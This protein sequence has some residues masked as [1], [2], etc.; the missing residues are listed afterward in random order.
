M[1]AA[2]VRFDYTPTARQAAAHGSFADELLY[3]GAAGGGKTDYL[4]AEVLTTL[5]TFPGSNGVI[6]RRTY[7]DLRRPGGIVE[8][9]LMRVPPELGT[10][11]AGEHKWR[12]R[13][14][15]L[16]E[17]GHLQRDATVLQY[18]GAEFA[19]V[20]FD[21]LEQ[22]TEYQYLYLRSRLRVAGETAAEFRR[23]GWRPRSIASANPGG[24]GHGWVKARF[25]DA[26]V[27]P[28]VI[29]RP[30]ATLDE[31]CPGTRVFLPARVDDNPHLDDSYVDRLRNLPEDDRRAL[32]EGDWDVYAGQR[33]RSFRRA[34]HVV[35]PEDVP[36]SPAYPRGIGVDYGFDAPF[37][38]L[39]G[40]LLPDD[41]IVVYRE[42][43]RPGLTPEE[44]AR[45]ILAVEAE[46]ERDAASGRPGGRLW[47]DPSTYARDPSAPRAVA[48]APDLPPPGSIAYKYRQ[49]GLPVRKANNNRLAGVA[50]V[51]GALRIRGDRRPR[52][53]I[54]S[55]CTNLIRTLPSLT[56]SP[57][58]PEDV[59]TRAEDH[60]YD[61]LR[62]LLLGM[63]GPRRPPGDPGPRRPESVPK[64]VTGGLS[65]QGF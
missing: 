31:P 13:N 37:A 44:Q 38:A 16:L 32:L 34:V 33:F 19:V 62:Y 25:I 51:A 60:A 24:P 4:I 41:L 7:P 9:L 18:Q 11:N 20:A 40:A 64:T 46:G 17:L 49:A 42:L 10:Y 15:S 43:Y 54:Y 36:L 65:K 30:A 14:G 6:F 59:D 21:Q 45:A 26:P 35:D 1:T 48:S 29:W 61:A 3:G 22:F 53:L 57:T 5:L 28:G 63:L 8:R 58:N 23:L 39:W 2:E 56:R 12:F 47:I 55:T 52:L 50:A 27:P